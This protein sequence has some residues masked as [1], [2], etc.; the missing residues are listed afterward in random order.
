[1]ALYRFKCPDCGTERSRIAKAPTEQTCD[2][3]GAMDRV[4]GVPGVSVVEKLDN[5]IMVRP[6]ERLADQ[7]RLHQEKIRLAEKKDDQ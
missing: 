7:P 6:L 3:G 1:M 4:P 5:G 2:C